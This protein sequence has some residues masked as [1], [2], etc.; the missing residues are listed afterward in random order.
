[1]SEFEMEF[2]QQLIELIAT[3]IGDEGIKAFIRDFAEWS[4]CVLDDEDYVE[5]E[6]TESSESDDDDELPMSIDVEEE[7]ETEVDE[8]GFHSLKDCVVKKN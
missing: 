4:E 5:V 3:R 2:G 7:Y 8:N 6:E 1:M